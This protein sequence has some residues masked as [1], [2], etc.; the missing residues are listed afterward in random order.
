MDDNRSCRQHDETDT[1][2]YSSNEMFITHIL[3]VLTVGTG[4]RS[5]SL[6]ALRIGCI[7]H[8][9]PHDA[10]WLDNDT[11]CRHGI[12]RPMGYNEPQMSFRTMAPVRLCRHF[13]S[14]TSPPSRKTT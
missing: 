12:C 3:S 11:Y 8:D 14:C 4:C 5:L 10:D 1:P 2:Q 13:L 9:H 7:L 6:Y